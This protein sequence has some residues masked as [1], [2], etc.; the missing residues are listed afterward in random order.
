MSIRHGRHGILFLEQ[1]AITAELE[2]G[3]FFCGNGFL[4][5]I[6]H[7]LPNT[8]NYFKSAWNYCSTYLVSVNCTHHAKYA[9]AIWSEKL[10]ER[11]LLHK[12]L[13]GV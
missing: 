12:N 6:F 8:E 13:V 5:A 2:I 7:S 3:A 10:P 1:G 11:E 4:S 9:S